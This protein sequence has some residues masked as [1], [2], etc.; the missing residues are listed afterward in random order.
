MT[1]SIRPR[2]VAMGLAMLLVLVG[3]SSASTAGTGGSTS[4]GGDPDSDKL[5]QV[6]DRGILRLATDPAYPP[7]SFAVEGAE[8]AADT[9]C[10]PTELTAPEVDGYDVAVGEALAADLGVEA[11]FVTPE[12]TELIAGNW[13]DRW[14]LAFSSVGITSGRM[15]SLYYTQP[16]YATPERFYV[17]SGSDADELADLDGARIGVCTGCYADLYLQHAL[18]VPGVDVTYRVD[19]ARIVGYESEHQGLDDVAAR[20]LDAFLCQETAGNQAIEEGLELRPLDPPAY[21]A[22]LGG[23]LDRFSGY[24]VA[25]FYD[26]VNQVVRALHADGTLADLSAGFFGK[27]YASEAAAFDLGSLEQTVT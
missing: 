18:D 3:C 11:C 26:R 5:A 12:W 20:K 10:A 15:E 7:A 9:T 6:L 8:R 24:D 19:D 21:S 4:P 23:V 13:S 2:L 1:K 22:F 27:D 17:A 25:A 16:Y 14:D